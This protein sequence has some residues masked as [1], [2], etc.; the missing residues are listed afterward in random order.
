MVDDDLADGLPGHDDA[1]VPVRWDPSAE[2]KWTP[3][4]NQCMHRL[5][6]VL[7]PAHERGG[8]YELTSM[9]WGLIP[10]SASSGA[11][12]LTTIN[13]RVEGLAEVGKTGGMYRRELDAGHRCVIVC[14]GF[15]EWRRSDEYD[16]GKWPFF[17]H[18]KTPIRV[19]ESVPGA[20]AT[21]YVVSVGPRGMGQYR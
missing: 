16:D 1:V 6:A 10:T 21:W 5:Q 9:R 8:P 2:S 19:D 17:I 12:K 7:L 13:A 14:S 4:F 15:F 11:P 20:T 3:A 18:D